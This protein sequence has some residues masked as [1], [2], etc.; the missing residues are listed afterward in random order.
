MVAIVF[1][2]EAFGASA[3]DQE[4]RFHR[5]FIGTD[6]HNPDFVQLAHAFGAVGVRATTEEIGPALRE[7]LTLE[8]PVVL[9][10]PIPTMMPPFQITK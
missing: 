1:N 9:E 10:V 4:H 5:R 6:L 8:R 7:A 3:W 2:N